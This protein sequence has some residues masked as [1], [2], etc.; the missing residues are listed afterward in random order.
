MGHLEYDWELP[1]VR[2]RL[3]DLAKSFTLVRYDARGNGL[4]DWDVGDV[5]FDAWVRD[6]ETVV[7]A[8]GLDR[9]PLL[10]LSQ[11]CAISIAYAARHPDRVSRLI[12]Y[13][14]FATGFNKRK[15]VT[16]AERDRWVAMKTLMK[17]GWGSDDA[18]FRQLFTSSMM[19]TA[20]R[21]QADVFNEMQ[22]L[23]ASPDCAV[24][25]LDA[26]S[27]FDVRHLLP[28]VQAPTLVMHVRDDLRVPIGLGRELA[29]GIPN[30]RFV[31]LPG[32]NHIMLPQDPGVAQFS[33]ELKAFVKATG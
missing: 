28:Q 15:N 33:N 10:G 22:R 6:M 26:V 17:L 19:P 25:Y 24:R 3:L 23:S 13:G 14:G 5:S 1:I 18:T 12:L 27:D 31:A 30:A 29:A 4:S 7:D 11:G 16:A 21:E 2:S 20:T 32:K 8:A 9:F